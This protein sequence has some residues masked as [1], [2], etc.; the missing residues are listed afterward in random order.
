M[1][2]FT[3]WFG[4]TY[5]CNR[6][7]RLAILFDL[8]CWS[9]I[10]SEL[11]NDRLFVANS[12]LFIIA[13]LCW[14]NRRRSFL[15][16]GLGS[17]RNYFNH[18]PT[19]CTFRTAFTHY[20]DL[21]TPPLFD[22]LECLAQYAISKGERLFLRNLITAQAGNVSLLFLCPWNLKPSQSFAAPS[23]AN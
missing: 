17:T 20:L 16:I 8:P 2:Y 22:V 9:L 7:C 14:P 1:C 4:A 5:L 21:T 18:F 10:A 6:C 19:P 11:V 3:G 15:F 23:G 13:M 12:G